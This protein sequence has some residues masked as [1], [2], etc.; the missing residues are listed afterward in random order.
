MIVP[1]CVRMPQVA[2]PFVSPVRT[3]GRPREFDIDDALDK[4]VRVFSE[5]GYHATSIG[6]LTVAMEVGLAAACIVF[7]YRMST[8][9]RVEPERP[10]GCVAA[11][12]ANA[13]RPC[14]VF[15]ASRSVAARRGGVGVR[16]PEVPGTF[17]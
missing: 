5:R 14:E 1:Y 6:D 17:S 10:A 13:R 9:F 8:L 3:R 16:L 11:A 2:K 12:S 15:D 7:V 4:A